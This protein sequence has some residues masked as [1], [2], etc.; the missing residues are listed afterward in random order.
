M[1]AGGPLS[2]KLCEAWQ[3]KQANGVHCADGDGEAVVAGRRD[4]CVSE[5]ICRIVATGV[6]C[7]NDDSDSGLPRLFYFLA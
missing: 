6:A 7:R 5:S 4:D 3:C 1:P 2:A